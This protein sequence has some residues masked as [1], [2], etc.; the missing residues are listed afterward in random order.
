MNLLEEIVRNKR[1]EVAALKHMKPF[2]ELRETVSDAPPVRDFEGAIRGTR[3][4]VIAEIKRASPSKGVLS[5]EFDPSAIA[6]EYERGGAAALSVLTD[7]RF[8]H[9]DPSHLSRARE[10]C[11]LPVL[12]KDFILDEYQVIESRIL[13][14]DAILLIARLLDPGLLRD[15]IAAAYAAGMVAVVEVHDESE[16]EIALKAGGRIIGVNNRDLST[17]SFSLDTSLRLRPNIPR[18]ITAVSES[19]V[20]SQEDVCRL[21]EK[22]FD[23]ILIGEELMKADDR[24]LT[25]QNLRKAL[26]GCSRTC[27]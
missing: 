19:G 3:P 11:S 12:R 8:F 17:F 4:S 18:G 16:I 21:A 9:G 20:R 5:E 14:A 7:R 26:E 13:S 1:D 22:G 15:L 23:A 25:L 27:L 6:A 10:A 2:R 24:A